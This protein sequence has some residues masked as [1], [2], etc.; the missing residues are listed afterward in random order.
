MAFLHVLLLVPETKVRLVL[1][2]QDL[3]IAVAT[4]YIWEF[5]CHGLQG[6]SLEDIEI[7]FTESWL[8]RVDVF[9]YL[10]Y[11]ETECKETEPLQY[12]VV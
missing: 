5:F 10:R 3:V 12:L 1:F 11:T 2:M 6:R 9:Y 8:K 7:L 4:S